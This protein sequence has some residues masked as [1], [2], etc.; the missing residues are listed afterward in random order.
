MILKNGRIRL[1]QKGYKAICHL[2]DLRSAWQYGYPCCEWCGASNARLQHHHI[3]FRS[4]YGSDTLD[5]LILLCEKCHYELAHG[6]EE[7]KYRLLFA[8]RIADPVGLAFSTRSDE[9]A[10]EIYRKYTTKR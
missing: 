7:K 1:S 9:D 5:N 6:V 10:L 3:I 8:Q 4:A 2:V